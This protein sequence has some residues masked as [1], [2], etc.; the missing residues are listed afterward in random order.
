MGNE[1]AYI[2]GLIAGNLMGAGFYINRALADGL[3]KRAI[4]L[5]YVIAFTLRLV[6][7]RAFTFFA[8]VQYLLPTQGWLGLLDLHPQGLSYIGSVAGLLLGGYISERVCRLPRHRLLDPIASGAMLS[9]AIGR[10]AE[11]FVSIGQGSFVENPALRFF[12]LAVKNEWGE[13]YYAVFMLEALIALLILWDAQ[14]RA[15]PA[16]ERWQRALF[17]FFCAQ[18]L[19]ESLLAETIKWGFVRVH[20]LFC[21]IGA[22]ALLLN[23]VIKGRR[24]G[25]PRHTWLTPL[26]LLPCVIAL[27]IG[28]EFALDR[29]QNTPPWALYLV[30]ASA[31][32]LLAGTG[33]RLLRAE[34]SRVNARGRVG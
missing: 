15:R 29:W 1:A 4:V 26:L 23:W 30:M 8:R 7:S 11:V 31:L 2:A 17:L 3:K 9:L 5:G 34:K 22:A 28:L 24:R 21:A 6:L 18:M 33:I 27:L 16:G 19:C 12:P 14:R 32:A 20:Q 25:L 13:W 10:A